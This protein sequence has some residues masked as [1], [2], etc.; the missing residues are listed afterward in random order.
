MTILIGQERWTAR[1][2]LPRVLLSLGARDF[3]VLCVVLH[4]TTHEQ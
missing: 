3:V 1:L 4:F 2:V